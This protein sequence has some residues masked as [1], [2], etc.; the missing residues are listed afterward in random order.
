MPPPRGEPA[1][2]RLHRGECHLRQR[3]NDRVTTT[4]KPCWKHEVMAELID[5]LVDGEAGQVRGELEDD[6]ARLPEVEGAEVVSIDDSGGLHSMF[7]EGGMP[8]HLIRF[9]RH[10]EGNV[11][12]AAGTELR[13]RSIGSREEVDGSGRCGRP[14]GGGESEA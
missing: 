2:S 14:A 6:T 3:G 12:H 8:A 1:R 7:R 10:P 9:I 13:W 11:V 4:L 5:G